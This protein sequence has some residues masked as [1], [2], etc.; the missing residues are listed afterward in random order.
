MLGAPRLL[1]VV[2]LVWLATHLMGTE[3][4]AAGSISGPNSISIWQSV[5]WVN[6]GLVRTQ[7]VIPDRIKIVDLKQVNRVLLQP[8]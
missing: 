7:K 5:S 8:H 6:V 2:K 4:Y 3:S 1:V